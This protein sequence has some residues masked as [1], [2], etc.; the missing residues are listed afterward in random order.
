MS[1]RKTNGI[2]LSVGGA[3]VLAVLVL[4]IGVSI[5]E[6]PPKHRVTHE[7]GEG[8][9]VTVQVPEDYDE[10]DYREIAE[11]LQDDYDRDRDYAFQCKS[12]KGETDEIKQEIVSGSNPAVANVFH[13]EA[14][15]MQ[16]RHVEGVT[17]G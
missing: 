10:S 11:H 7:A 4:I 14:G 6:K 9:N 16:F 15:E 8:T 13:D 3:L 12:P 17:C 1:R 2:I 5:A